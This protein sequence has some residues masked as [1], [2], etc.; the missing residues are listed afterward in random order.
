VLARTPEFLVTESP[1][2][3]AETGD[4]RSSPEGRYAIYN[5]GLT[6]QLLF[7]PGATTR[8][9]LTALVPIDAETMDRIHSLTRL[10]RDA[11][12]LNP[13]TD[14]RITPLR[15]RRLRLMMQAVDGRSRGA[16]YREIAIAIYGHERVAAELWKT[17]S[18]R[19]A[20]IG[21]VE[22]G[23]AMISGGYLGL[24]RHRRRS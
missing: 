1:T 9:S 22:G 17:S 4:A 16:T 23:N 14:T 5:T 2:P 6:L 24:L 12:G 21:L 13:I 19:D 11:Y 18:I 20:V 15:R 7:L 3:L 8:D 10:W